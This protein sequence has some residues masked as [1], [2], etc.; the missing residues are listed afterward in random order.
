STALAL[1]AETVASLGG[2]HLAANLLGC[3]A[4]GYG[5]NVGVADLIAKATE[6]RAQV[7][8]LALV[9]AAFEDATSTDSWRRA[10]AGTGRY[11][12][13]LATN[14]YTLAD[15]ERRAC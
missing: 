12:E 8:G 6:P 7:I 5:R 1:T 14:G 15:V 2:N 10:D 9:L 4:S 13:F 11:L 3:D